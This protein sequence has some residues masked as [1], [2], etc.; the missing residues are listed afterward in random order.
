MT[1][2]ESGCEE[3]GGGEVRVVTQRAKE[4]DIFTASAYH[5]LYYAVYPASGVTIIP[6][7]QKCTS[8]SEAHS[9]VDPAENVDADSVPNT[10]TAVL[11]ANLLE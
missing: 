6:V 2:K 4:P 7:G 8:P 1:M 11:H 9:I 10:R 5:W 3:H